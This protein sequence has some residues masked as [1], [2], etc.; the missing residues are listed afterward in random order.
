MTAKPRRVALYLRVSTDGQSTALQRRD[1]V[2]AC[3]HRGWEVTQVT[4]MPGLAEP[5]AVRAAQPL[6][7]PRCHPP[8]L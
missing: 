8:P 5:R 4:R 6:A 3:K 1:R 7:L 2:E